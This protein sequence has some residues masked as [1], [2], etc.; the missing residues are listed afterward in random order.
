M[1]K[2]AT[3]ALAFTLAGCQTAPVSTRA[4][5]YNDRNTTPIKSLTPA[6]VGMVNTVGFVG[7]KTRDMMALK[8]IKTPPKKLPKNVNLYDPL[9]MYIGGYARDVMAQLGEPYRERND[10]RVTIWQYKYTYNNK[11]CW[12]DLYLYKNKY[13][14]QS[15]YAELRGINQTK[16]DRRKCF[17]NKKVASK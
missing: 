3:L 10:H 6:P 7:D 4:N 16:A 13:G 11:H 1:Y 17:A 5:T 9:G 12:L 14:M 15:T 2:Y 8:Y